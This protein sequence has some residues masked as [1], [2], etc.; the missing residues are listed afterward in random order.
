MIKIQ[1]TN[2]VS[3]RNS[4]P[5][6]HRPHLQALRTTI[7]NMSVFEVEDFGSTAAIN[8]VKIEEN[9][10]VTIVINP[11]I[12]NAFIRNGSPD[13]WARKPEFVVGKLADAFA[14]KI[15]DHHPDLRFSP[16]RSTSLL[17]RG[18]LRIDVIFPGDRTHG[19][20]SR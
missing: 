10:R 8:S 17:S 18:I 15:W 2:S 9:D 6:K 1:V 19:I 5:A 11:F 16:N 14:S 20:I 12:R 13:G 3:R 4:I 7:K